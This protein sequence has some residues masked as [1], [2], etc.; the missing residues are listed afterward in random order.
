MRIAFWTVLIFACVAAVLPARAA[1]GFSDWGAIIV[2]GDY[3]AHDGGDSEVFDDARHDIGAALER[4]GFQPANV[5]E[6]SVRPA[7]YNAPQPQQ[8]DPLTISNGLWDLSNRTGAGCFVYFTSHGS[9]DGVVVGSDMIAPNAMASMVNNACGSRPTVVVVSA[10]YSGVFVPTL[11]A[12][13]RMVFTAARPDRTS[14]GCGQSERYTFFDECFLGAMQGSHDFPDLAN[15]VRA[16]V[17]ARETK[18]KMSPPSEPQL[19]IG[20]NAVAGLPRW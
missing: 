6:F 10:C 16:C 8:S 7:R 12:P 4:V 3:R 18:E 19:Y 13:N 14:F 15:T 20:A 1:G 5:A 9:P 17:A 11:A 2:A